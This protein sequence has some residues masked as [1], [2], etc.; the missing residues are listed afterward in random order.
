MAD[1]KLFDKV[2]ELGKQAALYGAQAIRHAIHK[3]GH[4]FIVLATGSSQFIMLEQLVQLPDIDWTAVSVFHLDEYIGLERTHKA[5]FRRYLQTRFMHPLGYKPTFHEING[6]A[7]PKQEIERLNQLIMGKEIAV[8]FAGI[9]N[10]CHLAFND[11]P[12]DFENTDP[13]LLVEL[14]DICRRQQVEGGWFSTLAEVPKQAISMSIRQIM[15]GKLIIALA[16]G[17]RKADALYHALECGVSCDY[18]ASILQNHDNA[19]WFL[20]QEAASRLKKD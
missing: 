2:E 14:D 11:P 18:P 15:K 16:Q 17:E 5:S 20:D 1:I 13:Y 7:P 6:E 12:A 3:N 9:G 4:A 19:V 10:N 8:V